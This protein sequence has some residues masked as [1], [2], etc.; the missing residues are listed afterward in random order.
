MDDP[1]APPCKVVES[2][3]QVKVVKAFGQGAKMAPGSLLV[4][5]YHTHTTVYLRIPQEEQE[6]VTGDREVLAE[7]WKSEFFK[8]H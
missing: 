7:V 4:K 6:S 3:K 8:A 2:K 1:W 5:L